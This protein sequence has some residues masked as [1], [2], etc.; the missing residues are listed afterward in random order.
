MPNHNPPIFLKLA[1]RCCFYSTHSTK[2][3]LDPASLN[4]KW[5]AFPNGICLNHI[6]FLLTTTMTKLDFHDMLSYGHKPWDDD[7]REQKE[8][9][10]RAF[11]AA[12]LNDSDDDS[13]TVNS[14]AQ[15]HDDEGI[16]SGSEHDE[17]G[18]ASHSESAN[19]ACSDHGAGTYG[20]DNDYEGGGHYDHD[21]THDGRDDGSDEGYDG[22]D[23]EDDEGDDYDDD[24]GYD[25]DGY[26]YDSD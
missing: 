24:D 22:N 5:R 13:S 18:S 1:C 12:S 3:R 11:D 2:R 25:D 21:A 15:G 26:D 8:A 6:F 17:G 9:L 16:S 4:L 23:Y 10:E 20:G 7:Y 19:D 14:T